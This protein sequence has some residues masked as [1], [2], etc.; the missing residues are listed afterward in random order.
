MSFIGGKTVSPKGIFASTV[1]M[2]CTM[3]PAS[4]SFGKE[5]R[6]KEYPTVPFVDV[7]VVDSGHGSGTYSIASPAGLSATMVEEKQARARE[8]QK[9]KEKKRKKADKERKAR[10][11]EREEERERLRKRK[12]EVKKAKKKEEKAAKKAAAASMNTNKSTGEVGGG[13]R[14]F[15]KPPTPPRPGS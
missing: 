1:G 3:A 9:K 7:S 13:A 5:L 15:G 2:A 12:L 10:A 8:R 6:N 14:T 4:V 11:A